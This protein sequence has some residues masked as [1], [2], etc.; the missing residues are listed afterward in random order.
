M[1]HKF[2]TRDLLLAFTFLTS[3]SSVSEFSCYYYYI[4]MKPPVFIIILR[5]ALRL[6][7]NSFP[8]TLFPEIFSVYNKLKQEKLFTLGSVYTTKAS[9]A[10]LTPETDNKLIIILLRIPTDLRHASWLSVNLAYLTEADQSVGVLY[11]PPVRAKSGKE[12]ASLSR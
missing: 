9:G 2:P 1:F 5:E 6:N 10:Y 7:H 3:R 11:C 4:V 12:W 8:H